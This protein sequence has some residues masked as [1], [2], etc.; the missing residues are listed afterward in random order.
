VRR[1]KSRHFQLHR[2]YPDTGKVSAV[3]PAVLAE[4]A[5]WSV[6]AFPDGKR[7]LFWGRLADGSDPARRVHIL[8][9]ESGKTTPFAPQLP[10]APPLAVHPDGKSVLAFVTFG[11]L[12]Q[13]I[14]VTADGEEGR[15]LFPVTGKAW[16]VDPAPDGGLYVSTIDNPAEL[17]RVP[18]TGG[19]PDRLATASGSLLTSPVQLPDG[20]LV[21]PNQ[22]LGRRR[23]LISTPAGEL[24]PF[25]EAG[26]QATLPAALVGENRLAFLSGP[27]GKPPSITI[28][29]APEGR[30]VRRLEGSSGV[31]PQGLVASPDGHTIYYVDAGTLYSIGV[32]GGAPKKLRAANGVAV[33]PRMP[34]PSLIVSVNEATGVKLYR[35][36][37]SGGAEEPILFVGPHRLAPTPLS[38]GAVGPDGRIALTVAPSDSWFRSIGVLDPLTATLDRLIVPFDG[39]VQSPAWGRDGSILAMGVSMRSSLWRFQAGDRTASGNPFTGSTP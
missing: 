20:S 26:E 1:D 34:V 2:F 16:S 32:E 21:L 23:L 28:A 17:L 11:D 14:S 19:V 38:A 39:D 12:Q 15:I 18:P 6:R 22:V 27:V 3:G 29:T 8:D 7:A 13:A 4:S 5:T 37:I 24:K 9:V 33:D 35:M 31:T 30:I 36:P 25:L 10:L